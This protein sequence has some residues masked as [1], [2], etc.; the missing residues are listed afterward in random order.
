MNVIDLNGTWILNNLNENK[1]LHDIPVTI[2]GTVISGAL[3]NHLIDHP[4][5]ANNENQI[6]HLFNY[7]YSFS[8]TFTIDTNVLSS[9]KIVLSCDGLDTLATIFINNHK[10][11]ETNN[12]YRHYDIDIK[13]YIVNG[14]NT[15]EIKFSSPVQYLKNLEQQASNGLAYL[16]K[17][18]CMF[19]WDFG[20]KLPDSGI[21]KSISIQFGNDTN[22]PQL[23]FKQTHYKDSVE[24]NVS[25]ESVVTQDLSLVLTL[26]DPNKKL[27]TSVTFND[28]Q[29]LEHTFLIEHPHLWWP[30]GYG[31]QPLYT[32]NVTL[33]KDD[34]LIDCTD[35]AIGLRTIELN[36][37]NDRDGSKFEFLINNTPI[38]IKGTNM[39]IG[40]AILNQTR[41]YDLPA[42]IRDC[43]NSNINCIRVWGGAYYPSDQFFDLCNQ[44]GILVIQDCMFTSQSYPNDPAFLENITVELTQNIKRIAHHPSLILLFGNN[45]IDM[46]YTMLTS[47]DPR[48][49]NTRAFFDVPKITDEHIK[50]LMQRRYKKIF[51]ELISDIVHKIAPQI[52]YEHSSPNTKSE[53]DTQ[54]I[55][56]YARDGDFHYYLA[57][58]GQA[59]YESIQNIDARFISEMGFQSYPNMK[60][61]RTF[62]DKSE[63][64]P[65]SPV[66]LEHQK[67]KDGNAIID[68][69]MQTE[70]KMPQ[71]FTDYVYLSQVLAAIVMQYSIEHFR[72]ENDYCRG[73]LIWQMNDCWPTISWSGVDYFGRWKAQ[74]YLTKRFYAPILPIVTI[75]NQ[76]VSMTVANDSPSPFHGFLKWSL[77]QN[78]HTLDT[79]V[80]DVYVDAHQHSNIS[81]LQYHNLT[82]AQLK[83]VYLEY[84]LYESDSIIAT[85]VK[86]FVKPKAFQFKT[87]EITYSITENKQEYIIHLTSTQMAKYVEL[88]LNKDDCIFSDNYFDLTPTMPKSITVAK[89][90]LST[91]LDLHAFEEQFNIKSLNTTQL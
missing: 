34:K 39:I 22:V 5:Y 30:I 73:V 85:G 84:T 62:A 24:L 59:P 37:E 27:I 29:M 35:Y 50:N 53:K 2:P 6:Q 87:P 61:I 76:T 43:V 71:N 17:A 80:I 41:A 14:E 56:A 36:R 12:M 74:Q 90:S 82:Q 70:F 64:S 21:W 18:Q 4:Y 23:Q 45:E 81:P 31:E 8:R 46:T 55:F 44:Y 52:P 66:M 28:E 51:I 26:Y 88:D 60:T 7:D 58:D 11:I 49:E 42:Q 20:I 47:D 86:L 68:N 91:S 15:I 65:N 72:S 38:F 16:R 79:S 69:Y 3:E 48:T 75:K 63:Q 67:C 77:K 32:V 13:P 1:Y 89:Q 25:S 40:D 83:E 33:Y 9:N 57:Y 78:N 19:G 10:I 54:S